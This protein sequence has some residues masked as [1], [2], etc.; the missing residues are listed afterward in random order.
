M[1][2]NSSS[3]H[4]VLW[5]PYVHHRVHNGP[6][7]FPSWARSIQFTSP[8]SILNVHFNIIPHLRLCLPCG[9]S[10]RFSHQNLLSTS[11]PSPPTRAT[12]L[13][14][15]ILLDLMTRMMSGEQDRSG[16]NVV[17][18][19]DSLQA[20]RSGDRIPVRNGRCLP[21]LGPTQPPVQWVPGL[22][23]G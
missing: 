13:A 6:S 11:S 21:Y 23:W 19:S 20:G 12:R 2:V 15:L 9:L 1:K 22:S 14:H 18:Y 4:C 3:F 7:F 8:S 10:L 5:N 16:T 17:G